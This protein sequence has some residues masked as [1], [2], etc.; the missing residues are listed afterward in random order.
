MFIPPGYP[1]HI[2]IVVCRISQKSYYHR[3]PGLTNHAGIQLVL[4]MLLGLL[5]G[6]GIGCAAMKAAVSVRS[7]LV[8]EATLQN[9]V[10][11][12]ASPCTASTIFFF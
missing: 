4:Q 8:D 1:V 6:W 10:N 5:T 7:H 11:R 3:L 12:S 2:Y 9:A